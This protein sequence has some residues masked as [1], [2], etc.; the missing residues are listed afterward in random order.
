V[1]PL[2]AEIYDPFGV[3]NPIPEESDVGQAGTR[4]KAGGSIHGNNLLPDLRL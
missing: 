4:V 1:D 2:T 3:Q